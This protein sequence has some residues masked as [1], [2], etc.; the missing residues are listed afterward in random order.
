MYFQVAKKVQFKF[1]TTKN[2]QTKNRDSLTGWSGKHS[3]G[4]CSAE[5]K[6]MKS[7][8]CTP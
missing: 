7:T 1:L 8:S 2:K 6:C 4:N 3:G 5:F